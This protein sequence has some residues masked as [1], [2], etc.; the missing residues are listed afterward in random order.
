MNLLI[1]EFIDGDE[2]WMGVSDGYMWEMFINPLPA[3]WFF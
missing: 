1:F 2:D 3:K